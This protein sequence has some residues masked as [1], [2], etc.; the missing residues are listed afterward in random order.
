MIGYHSVIS[1]CDWLLQFD[2]LSEAI[3]RFVDVD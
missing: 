2:E 1:C 3:F